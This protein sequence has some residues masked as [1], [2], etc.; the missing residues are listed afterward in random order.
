MNKQKQ[1]S[2]YPQLKYFLLSNKSHDTIFEMSY[3]HCDSSLPPVSYGPTPMLGI[4]LNISVYD[5]M[6][7]NNWL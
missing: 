5:K 1:K 4:I 7:P 6:K 3:T 2:L